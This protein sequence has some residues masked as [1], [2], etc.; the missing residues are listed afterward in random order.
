MSTTQREYYRGLERASEALTRGRARLDGDGAV[1]DRAAAVHATLAD[2]PAPGT[3]CSFGC[4]HCCRFPVGIRL[5]EAVLL[6]DAI[7]EDASLR[8]AVADE[9]AATRELPWG[10]L[11]GRPCP[12]LRDEACASYDARPTPCRALTSFDAAACERSLTEPGP[13]PRDEAGWWRGLGAATVLD[14][15]IGARELRA[16][17]AAVL[18]CG[19]RAPFDVRAAA[20]AS[21]RAVPGAGC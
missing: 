3:A 18:A 14:E 17:L 8:Q 21:A 2:A 13:V 10:E 11:A 12:L 19:P 7:D 20:F 5:G 15:G 9:F 6:A 4:G 16:G 1:A